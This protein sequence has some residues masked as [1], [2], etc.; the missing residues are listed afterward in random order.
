VGDERSQQYQIQLEPPG[1]E[2]LAQSVQNDEMLQQ[3]I[4]Q[5]TAERARDEK[6]TFPDS[7]VLS[8]DT[9]N[10]RASIWPARNLTVEP[11][12][13]SY[14]RLFFEQRN[15]ERYGWD[16]GIATP[17]VAAG[18]F[19]LDV[20]MLPY[21]IAK[22]PCQYIDSDAGLCLPGDP[23]PF[24]LYPPELSWT[25]TLTEVAVILALVAVFP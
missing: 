7:P 9:Y 4:R 18:T 21:N 1:L 25:G 16:L 13:A 17:V 24:L 22:Q 23:V 19:F 5:E 12:Y 14:G 8:H 3:R 15:L 10:G 6:V 20:A 11:Y 2:K